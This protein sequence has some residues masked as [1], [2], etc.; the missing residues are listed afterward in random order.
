MNWAVDI[1]VRVGPFAFAAIVE[2]RVSAHSTGYA[3]AGDGEK[4]PILFLLLQEGAARG[5]DI[6]GQKYETDEI[7]G[8]YPRAIAQMKALLREKD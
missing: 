7:E 1:P 5:I 8:L 4:R 2:T 6:N 3:L